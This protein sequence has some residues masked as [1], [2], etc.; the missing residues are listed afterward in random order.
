RP[1][2][3]RAS[4]RPMPRHGAR[5]ARSA[6]QH[7]RP[8]R[9]SRRPRRPRPAPGS[10]ASAPPCARCRCSQRPAPARRSSRAA[11]IASVDDRTGGTD[12]MTADPRR[13]AGAALADALR[14]ARATTL[15]RTLDASDE[16]WRVPEQPGVNPVAW[17]LGHIAWFAEFWILRGPHRQSADGFVDA[18]RPP[19]IAGPDAV[20]DSARLAHAERW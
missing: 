12:A 2:A 20:F 19:T 15:A 13:L 1:A 6:R 8:R 7:R 16:A 4:A 18:A 10:S 17:E 3:A 9:R 5:A 14:N 11:G